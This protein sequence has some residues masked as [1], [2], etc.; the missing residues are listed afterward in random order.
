MAGKMLAIACLIQ[1]HE[2]HTETTDPIKVMRELWEDQ[3]QQNLEEE[4]LLNESDMTLLGTHAE[5]FKGRTRNRCK[6]KSCHKF[7]LVTPYK[8]YS[9]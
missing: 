3:I 9:L 2:A 4:Q 1:T 7:K 8:H 6:G 5:Y